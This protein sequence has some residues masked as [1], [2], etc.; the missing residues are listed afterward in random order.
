MFEV[1][2][3]LFVYVWSFSAWPGDR[4]GYATA[5]IVQNT[6]PAGN[7]RLKKR[8]REMSSTVNMYKMRND[9]YWIG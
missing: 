4:T 2:L 1:M 6:V 7:R 3:L 5:A 9:V 8:M